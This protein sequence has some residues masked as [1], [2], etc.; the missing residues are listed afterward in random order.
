MVESVEDWPGPW[1]ETQDPI[2]G[3]LGQIKEPAGQ[4]LVFGQQ[5]GSG[6]PGGGI[7]QQ[8][9][10]PIDQV[11]GADQVAEIEIEVGA[12]DQVVEIKQH[13]GGGGEGGGAGD[14][15]A[16]AVETEAVLRGEPERQQRH[17]RIAQGRQQ[18]AGD[19]GDGAAAHQ[20]SLLAAGEGLAHQVLQVG[21][22]VED[23]AEHAAIAG[24]L[25]GVV[26]APEQ[27]PGRQ[28][29]TAGP[30]PERAV[31]GGAL[32]GLGEQEVVEQA[33]ILHPVGGGEAAEQVAQ[34]ECQ[35]L[36]TGGLPLVGGPAGEQGALSQQAA[37][38]LEAGLHKAGCGI[39]GR[40]PLLPGQGVGGVA[41][42]AGAGIGLRPPGHGR[43]QRRQLGR[44]HAG[45]LGQPLK[46]VAAHG[47]GPGHRQAA[48]A[49]LITQ[50]GQVV[51]QGGAERLRV[52][53]GA[54]AQIRHRLIAGGD[55]VHQPIQFGP[56][57]G[58]QQE[59]PR[60]EEI[61]LD[62]GQDLQLALDIEPTDGATAG[63]GAGIDLEQITA[64]RARPQI[65]SLGPPL[66][67]AAGH[68]AAGGEAGQAGA[69]GEAEG[70]AAAGSDM[71]PQGGVVDAQQIGAGVEGA[72]IDAGGARGDSDLAIVGL[73][74]R[75]HQLAQQGDEV[76][77]H[78]HHMQQLLAVQQPVEIGAVVEVAGGAAEAGDQARGGISICRRQHPDALDA[79]GIGARRRQG[80]QAQGELVVNQL[81]QLFAG[82]LRQAGIGGEPHRMEGQVAVQVEQTTEQGIEISGQVG[83]VAK[84]IEAAEADFSRQVQIARQAHHITDREL[85]RHIGDQLAV[86]GA[87]QG[88]EL[89]VLDTWG[90]QSHHP[91]NRQAGAIGA[92][93]GEVGDRPGIALEAGHQV[94]AESG[95]L[96][97]EVGALAGPTASLLVVAEQIGQDGDVHAGAQQTQP[98]FSGDR[99]A[100]QVCEGGSQR[101]QGAAE[102]IGLDPG[103]GA[104]R[105]EG[106]EGELLGQGGAQAVAGEARRRQAAVGQAGQ[107]GDREVGHDLADIGEVLDDA[108]PEGVG[109]VKHA[110]EVVGALKGQDRVGAGGPHHHPE[111]EVVV[112]GGQ[113]RAGG[114]ERAGALQH[115]MAGH[116]AA[117]R[118]FPEGIRG[119][120]AFALRRNAIDR[121]DAEV[122]ADR[123]RLPAP[124]AVETIGVQHQPVGPCGVDGAF[125]GAEPQGRVGGCVDGGL[126]GFEGREGPEQRQGSRCVVKQFVAEQLARGGGAPEGNGVEM[127]SGSRNPST[128]HHRTVGPGDLHLGARATALR[129]QI[130]HQR[131]GELGLVLRSELEAEV[132]AGI[133]GR[134]EPQQMGLGIDHGALKRHDLIHR[135]GPRAIRQPAGIG[136]PLH[137]GR[138]ADQ[139]GGVEAEGRLHR[140]G[141]PGA[142]VQHGHLAIGQHPGEAFEELIAELPQLQGKQGAGIRPIGEQIARVVALAQGRHGA[143]RHHP[144]DAG[145]HQSGLEAQD[146]LGEDFALIAPGLRQAEPLLQPVPGLLQQHLGQVDH[147]GV[148]GPGAVEQQLAAAAAVAGPAGGEAREAVFKHPLE[149]E[150]RRLVVSGKRRQGGK[151]SVEIHRPPDHPRGPQHTVRLQGGGELRGEHGIK[152]GRT[153]AGELTQQGSGRLAG[154][155][156]VEGLAQQ[157]LQLLLALSPEGGQPS[158]GKIPRSRQPALEAAQARKTGGH[159]EGAGKTARGGEVRA[160]IDCRIRSGAVQRVNNHA[161][162]GGLADSGFC[163]RWKASG[164]STARRN[165]ATRA[166]RPTSISASWLRMLFISS[167]E[168]RMA[169]TSWRAGSERVS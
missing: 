47:L 79:E 99:L 134:D 21:N 121:L 84:R 10:Q 16:D 46:Q 160:A 108:H 82:G 51:G 33:Q 18:L 70:Q 39:L 53:G 68:G 112:S 26:V 23:A 114:G 11:D 69:G 38:Q 63:I 3:G 27:Q 133:P 58:R 20:L 42:A 89:P 37:F 66:M 88:I 117:G 76:V 144:G 44:G 32:V 92:G 64:R 57:G 104:E 71:G 62:V 165:W 2:A 85:E 96:V 154:R 130:E 24:R 125:D 80:L 91:I 93:G 100:R 41:V 167:S 30:L 17:G 145:R 102:Q 67:P 15:V 4:R 116:E 119:R 153:A 161:G 147:R 157:P 1:I 61:A 128:Q 139:A 6:G 136:I 129:R 138:G 123:F 22:A 126:L 56:L 14:A 77:D 168:A 163:R 74:R 40:R 143:F 29:L 86:P 5:G 122:I 118:G 131:L 73:R 83:V 28:G 109:V 52:G 164:F 98:V 166:R 155:V 81:N 87:A 101:G 132:V 105:I 36:R 95:E 50:L 146:A 45:Q 158:G 111:P 13:A 65:E 142:E 156:E 115:R 151:E 25:Q 9:R 137:R 12:L 59:G 110:F 169:A 120:G 150:N 75:F 94:G 31:I 140:S 72:Q 43:Q 49:G 124:E 149:A 97:A 35:P 113:G 162:S 19:A 60:I 78:A 103:Q 135:V 8:W 141:R 148:L 106:G 152:H 107:G 159:G 127:G 54:D 55:R 48:V 7:G 34:I 90:V